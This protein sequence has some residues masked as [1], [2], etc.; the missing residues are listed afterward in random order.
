MLLGEY[1]N[2][3]ILSS[4]QIIS[5]GM[6]GIENSA[7][8]AGKD[9]SMSDRVHAGLDFM[10][11]I[12]DYSLFNIAPAAKSRGLSFNNN[13]SFSAIVSVSHVA[14]LIN[15]LKLSKEIYTQFDSLQITTFLHKKDGMK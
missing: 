15:Y 3:G 7:G 2:Y 4:A 5:S 1:F 10:A 9:S 6:N 8:G 14:S 11:N 12:N 13:Y